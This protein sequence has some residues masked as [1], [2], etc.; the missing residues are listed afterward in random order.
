MRSRPRCGWWTKRFSAALRPVGAIE[1]VHTAQS[2]VL[3]T[4]LNSA[5]FARLVEQETL[6]GS[7]AYSPVEFLAH[8]RKGIWKELDARR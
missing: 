6:D 4:L 3:T 8:V 7:L 5:R 2:R 1:R